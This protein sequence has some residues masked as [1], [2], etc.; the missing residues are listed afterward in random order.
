MGLGLHGGFFFIVFI[1][2]F[3]GSETHKL[4]TEMLTM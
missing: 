3:L 4:E 1:I 2:I